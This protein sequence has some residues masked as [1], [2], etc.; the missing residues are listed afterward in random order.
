ARFWRY[1]F[2]A[3]DSLLPGIATAALTTLHAPQPPPAEVALTSVLNALSTVVE[4]HVLI[5][6]DYHVIESHAIHQALGFLLDQLPPCLHLLIAGRA[7]PPL[8]LARLR[9]RGLLVEIRADD[10]RCTREEASH[11]LREVMGLDLTPEAVA[12]LETRT[13][14]WMAGLQLAA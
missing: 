2:T 11:F 1:T 12:A 3:L 14:G 9:A 13:E 7:D 8:P 5:L 10:L 4:D 6:D